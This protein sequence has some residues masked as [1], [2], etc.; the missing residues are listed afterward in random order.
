MDITSEELAGDHNPPLLR[1]DSGASFET[2]FVSP[3][4]AEGQHHQL[5]M[6]DLNARSEK[7]EKNEE[8]TSSSSSSDSDSDSNSDDDFFQIDAPELIQ[9]PP[10]PAPEPD[11]MPANPMI[12]LLIN[13]INVSDLTT[14]SSELRPKE[15]IQGREANGGACV[16]GVAGDERQSP[17][18]VQTPVVQSP[19]VQSPVVQVMVRS[20]AT[21]PNRIPSSVFTRSSA[22]AASPMEWSVASNESL[23]SIHMGNTS[24]SR[25]HVF[26]MGR[27]GDLTG[28][29]TSG[30]L[31]YPPPLPPLVSP[32]AMLSPGGTVR[33]KLVEMDEVDETEDAVGSAEAASANDEAMKEVM[34]KAAEVKE[35]DR[36]TAER[37]GRSISRHSDGSTTSFRS[38]AFPILTGDGR[39]GSIRRDSMHHLDHQPPALSMETPKVGAP[40]TVSRAARSA[41]TSTTGSRQR[42]WFSCLSCCSFCC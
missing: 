14:N 5:P 7:K 34:R 23:F 1:R 17:P 15:D 20:D 33:S 6:I 22:S 41:T 19:V 30:P 2:S 28:M 11:P 25:D 27:S 42:R 24:F 40:A 18:V 39:N 35:K 37:L 8:D 31:D 32:A 21:D 36:S 26:L 3:V 10:G 38:F 29:Y 9:M 16:A 13:H 4:A 12:D